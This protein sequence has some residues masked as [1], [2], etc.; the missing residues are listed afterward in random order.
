MS[1]LWIVLLLAVAITG[2]GALPA[3]PTDLRIQLNP[4]LTEIYERDP[5]A[6]RRIL[7][8]LTRILQRPPG[9]ASPSET[10]G[11]LDPG[12]ERLLRDNPLLQE[13]YR[14]DPRAALQQLR[15]IVA[16]GGTGS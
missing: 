11:V 6:A 3:E 7:D 15:D 16:A 4:A 9:S 5:A 2:N 14:I 13:A 1:R 10:R 8:Q 12:Q